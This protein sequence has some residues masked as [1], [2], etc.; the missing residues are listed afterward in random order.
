[1]MKEV[2]KI[3]VFCMV[4]LLSF[5]AMAQDEITDNEL[6]RY[7]MMQEVVNYMKKDISVEINKMIKAQEGMTGKRYQELSKTKGDEQMLAELEAL[8]WEIKF[9]EQTDKFKADRIDAIKS[10]NT[11]LA[12]K[13]VGNKGKTYKSIKEGLKEDESLK[14]RY[15]A[16]LAILKQP[17][18]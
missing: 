13:M 8:E 15:E 4:T 2:K 10:T 3:A 11:D 12:T 7:A 17:E 18:A 1:M 14:A 16:I 6:M 5:T 9:L